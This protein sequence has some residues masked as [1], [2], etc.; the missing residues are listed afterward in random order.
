MTTCSGS[1]PPRAARTNMATDRNSSSWCRWRRLLAAWRN[2]NARPPGRQRSP[3]GAGGHPTVTWPKDAYQ[4][5]DCRY[6]FPHAGQGK[7]LM[8]KDSELPVSLPT[9]PPPR[10]AARRDAIE[11]A[12]RKF[13]GV[14]EAPV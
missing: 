2:W 4:G 13:D 10:P 9:P 3:P 11:M 1:P 6:E 8:G 5:R 7:R 12:L 14:E